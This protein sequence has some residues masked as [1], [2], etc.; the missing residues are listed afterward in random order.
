MDR[1][2]VSFAADALE[3]RLS[4]DREGLHR[5]ATTANVRLMAAASV[6]KRAGADWPPAVLAA[7]E[8]ETIVQLGAEAAAGDPHPDLKKVVDSLRRLAGE[9]PPR[10]RFERRVA[11][12]G[13]TALNS[14]RARSAGLSRLHAAPAR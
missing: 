13:R 7:L 1:E 6:L 4:G 10:N 2:D 3:R 14:R 8:L 11:I 5:L 12:S 9:P